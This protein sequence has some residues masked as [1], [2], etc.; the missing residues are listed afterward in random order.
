MTLLAD[1]DADAGAQAPAAVVHALY[2]LVS[3]EATAEASDAAAGAAVEPADLEQAV[4]LRLLELLADRRPPADPARWVRDTVRAEVRRARRTARRELPYVDEATADPA[5][6]P[7][8]SAVGADER[9]ALHAAVGR[10]PGRCAG[11]LTAMLAPGDPTYREIAGKLGMSQG[12]L[13]PIRSRCLGCLR[14][15]LAAEVVVPEL[16][17]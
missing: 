8:R 9:R 14:R 13:G 4:W 17:G 3:A 7:E 10:L 1:A 12:S 6:C 15:M 11:L 16:R 2:P 5:R